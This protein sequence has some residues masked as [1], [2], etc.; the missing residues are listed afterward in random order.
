MNIIPINNIGKKKNSPFVSE[1]L[2]NYEEFNNQ[3]KNSNYFESHLNS[4]KVIFID[5]TIQDVGAFKIRG[6]TTGIN[7]I[8]KKNP[9]ITSI[10]C[11]SSGSFGISIANICKRNGKYP[12]A[13]RVCKCFFNNV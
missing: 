9:K 1:V 2:K 5:E 13:C 10:I 12:C 3:W 8:L 6:A 11:A 4:N 7:N